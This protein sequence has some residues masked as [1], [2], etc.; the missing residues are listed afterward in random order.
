[1]TP[2]IFVSSTI[3]DLHYLRDALKEQISLIG[4][5]P[6]LAE[7]GDIGYSCLKAISESQLAVFIVGKR[8][9]LN[10]QKEV[11]I[12]H[13]EFKTAKEKRKPSIF[14]IDKEVHSYK[15]V[16]DHDSSN[17]NLS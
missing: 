4:Y 3:S 9:N 17:T 5:N 2:N 10:Q 15:K 7:Y 11:S 14:L 1:M 16:H 8:Y 12:T 6:I 13:Q